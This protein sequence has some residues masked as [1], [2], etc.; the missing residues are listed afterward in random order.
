LRRDSTQKLPT[1][2]D[3]IDALF[4]L[5]RVLP[6]SIPDRSSRNMKPAPARLELAAAIL[7]FHTHC[8]KLA[9]PRRENFWSLNF[10]FLSFF[11][12]IFQTTVGFRRP[13]FPYSI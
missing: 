5:Y 8:D 1:T 6:G 12:G 11:A 9:T 13:K 3:G 2:E 10:F 7:W 4:A